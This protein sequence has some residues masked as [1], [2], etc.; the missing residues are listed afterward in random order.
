MLIVST[1]AQAASS[2]AQNGPAFLIPTLHHGGMSLAQAGLVAGAPIAGTMCTLV[3]WGAVVDRIGE[4]F[5]MITSLVGTTVGLA[6]SALVS[7]SHLALTIAM[8][9]TG[10]AAAGTA[11]ASGRVVVGWFPPE[12][13]GMVMGIRQIS[14]PVGVAVASLT[15]PIVAEAHGVGAALDVPIVFAALA[16]L[17]CALTIVDPPRPIRSATTPVANPYRADRYLARIHLASAL[18]VIPQFTVWSY[19]LVWLQIERQWS[20]GAAGL[21]VAA[22]QLLGSLGRI[23]AGHLS[24]LVGSRMRPLRWISALAAV[25]MGALGLAMS[26]QAWIAVPLIVLASV[27]TVA[28]NGLAFTA[29][30]ER[31]GPWWS[32]RA[33][34]VQNTGQFLTAAVVPSVLGSAI[35]A[36]SYAA[37]FGLTAAFP[38]A[39]LVILPLADRLDVP[40]DVKKS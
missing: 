17:A 39:A 29:T 20:A 19:M 31:A 27:V 21:L 6:A 28:D 9:V 26:A 25:T 33:L 35:T 1:I 32:G 34:G 5:V 15:M 11:A 12:R 38:L 18:L 30:A 36:T 22:A 4:R 3:L 7:G 14:Q 37:A 13:R 40:L 24:D 23:G 2:A 10:M 8:F 16:A